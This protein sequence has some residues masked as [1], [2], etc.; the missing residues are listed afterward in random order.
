MPGE[1]EPAPSPRQLRILQEQKIADLKNR[2]VIPALEALAAELEE[3]AAS[4]KLTKE[5]QGMKAGALINNLTKIL[6]SIKSAAV[7]VIPGP[8]MPMR[9]TTSLRA[10]SAIQLSDKQRMLRRQAAEA[11]DAEVVENNEQ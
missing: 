10:R 2:S 1:L 7:L 5:L 11:T 4:G 8:T 3:R 6:A 9:D